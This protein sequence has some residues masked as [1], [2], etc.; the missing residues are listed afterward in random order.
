MLTLVAQV[1]FKDMVRAEGALRT[2]LAA[3]L[4]GL[5][6]ETI[7]SSFL[8][9]VFAA[10][11]CGARSFFTAP[12]RAGLSIQTATANP[13]PSLARFVS[14][15]APSQWR[16]AGGPESTAEI[17]VGHGNQMRYVLCA[18]LGQP[19]TGEWKVVVFFVF[20]FFLLFYVFFSFFFS[21]GG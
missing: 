13:M 2:H 21:G 1:L 5:A 20:V 16:P 4:S 7:C 3:D 17:V 18:G 19:E 6:T 15:R 14:C 11:R 9:S 12:R 8:L 10:E